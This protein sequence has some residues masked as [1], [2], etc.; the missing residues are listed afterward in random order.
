ML[1]RNVLV[2]VEYYAGLFDVYYKHYHCYLNR[3][4][5]YNFLSH[6][7]FQRRKADFVNIYS[8]LLDTHFVSLHKQGFGIVYIYSDQI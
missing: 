3:F 2:I 8:Q 6:L 7:L 1:K 4:V 5:C